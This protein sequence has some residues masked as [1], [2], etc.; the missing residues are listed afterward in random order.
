MTKEDIIKK[1]GSLDDFYN[2]TA[3][4]LDKLK[5]KL[6]DGMYEIC[7]VFA[8]HDY[9]TTSSCNGHGRRNAYI[10]FH[11]DVKSI[12][13]L[14]NKDFCVLAT[15]RNGLGSVYLKLTFKWEYTTIQNIISALCR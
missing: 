14:E 11:T 7:K 2:C 9:L 5:D 3:T 6:D 4:K 10:M 1:Y 13:E 8:E 15:S 12:P